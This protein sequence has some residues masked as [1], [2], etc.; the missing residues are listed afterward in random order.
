MRRRAIFVRGGRF[1]AL[2][3][4]FYNNSCDA[5]GPD[6]GGAAIRTLSQYEG[7]PVYIVDSVFG[8][9][10]GQG[11]SCSNGGGL[12][13][14]GVS[15]TVINSEFS[16]NYA[17]GNGANPAQSGTLGGG[18]GAAICNDGNTFQLKLCG[19]SI[20][21][22]TANEGGTAIFFVSNDRTGTLTIE[23]SALWNNQKG[24][25]ETAG[26]PGIFYLGDG[27]PQVINS[28]IDVEPDRDVTTSGS[29]APSAGNKTDISPIIST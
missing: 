4:N 24:T 19:T 17:T 6:A 26:Y 23:N 16:H 7:Q 11:N 3:S 15:Y 10:E 18:S 29:S 28:T 9:A 5:T 8:G 1:Q 2:H 12:S 25:F 22:N 13:S 20:H 21:D 27:V 14:I